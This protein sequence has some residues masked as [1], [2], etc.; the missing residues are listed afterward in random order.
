MLFFV[1][2]KLPCLNPRKQLNTPVPAHTFTRSLQKTSLRAHAHGSVSVL[3]AT[4]R[5]RQGTRGTDGPQRGTP[6]PPSTARQQRTATAE[7]GRPTGFQG[8]H[9][10]LV[11]DGSTCSTLDTSMHQCAVQSC[12]ETGLYLSETLQQCVPNSGSGAPP[13][14]MLVFTPARND[15]QPAFI[16]PGRALRVS[17]GLCKPR[18]VR[19]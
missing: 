15:F 9:R 8:E 12:R 17:E 3:S 2:T 5:L 10:H 11:A 7:P 16:S 13:H 1:S 4:L 6:P 19:E 18:S 14:S